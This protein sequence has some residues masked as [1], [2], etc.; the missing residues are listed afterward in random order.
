[1]LKSL[2]IENYAIIRKVDIEF[3][4]S[5]NIVTG[6]TGAGKSI[7]LGALGLIM[8]QR[9]DTTVL[10]DKN[11]KCIV[12][13]RFTGYPPEIN[14]ILRQSDLDIYDELII[15]REISSSGK[16]R[17][18]ANDT[19]VRLDVLQSLSAVLVDLNSQFEMMELYQNRFQLAVIDALA[20]NDSLLEV[21]R[22]QFGQYKII[23][24][25][26]REL[27]SME[28][29]QIRE[30][31]FARFQFDELEKAELQM[32]E[33]EELERELQLLESSEDL[34]LLMEET[35]F[36]LMESE[37]AVRDVLRELQV[38]WEKFGEI[39]EDIR[40]GIESFSQMH[41]LLED[42]GSISDKVSSRLDADPER[43]S[44]VNDRLN[45]L[46]GLE[47]KH[48][49][50]GLEELIEIR[51]Q[52]GQMIEQFDG[53][54]EKIEQLNK[55]LRELENKL[56]KKAAELSKSR[57]SVFKNLETSISERLTELAMPSASIKVKHSVY[58]EFGPSGKDE[59]EFY[60]KANR[61]G[62][63]QALKKVA[64]GGE[65]ARLMLALKSTVADAMR[66]PTMIFDE[67]DSGVSG[68]V[69]GRMGDIIKTLSKHHQL[70]CITHSPQVAARAVRHY[71]VYKEDLKSRTIT[72]VKILD[73]KERI[74]EIAK[75]LSGD[76]PSSFAL[77]NAKE[78]IQT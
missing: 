13:A 7:L 59:I 18:F 48:N 52:L 12:E 63:F 42:I 60:F 65:S 76:P 54:S 62:D 6:E 55:Q 26:L 61:G 19:P 10:Y 14:E 22:S 45:I 3:D 37:S 78:L 34:R 73:E 4:K 24:K 57:C 8:G 16:S 36:K 71:F 33:Q 66:L 38:K 53:K 27:E 31:D 23:R 69:A 43:L 40:G 44:E 49:V 2:S 20:K 21:Y 25:E 9:A 15:R 47:R 56:E 72:H 28:S 75:M 67:I 35:G 46:Y 39:D 5:L 68:E 32:G 41:A 1:M 11:S 17:A 74:A 58:G 77:E 64:S 29:Q 50:Q 30:M 70:I 51:D